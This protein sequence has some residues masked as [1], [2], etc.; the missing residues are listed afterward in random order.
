[1]VVCLISD[2][3]SFCSFANYYGHLNNFDATGTKIIDFKYVNE[4]GDETEKHN[5]NAKQATTFNDNN[6]SDLTWEKI[7]PRQT[8]RKSLH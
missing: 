4:M 7:G 5:D 8:E 1:M 2:C 6:I 3:V